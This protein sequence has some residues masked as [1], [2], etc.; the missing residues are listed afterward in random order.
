MI[1]LRD[2]IDKPYEGPKTYENLL[3]IL[4][5]AKADISFFGTRCIYVIPYKGTYPIESLV[6]RIDKLIQENIEFSEMERE[7]GEKLTENISILYFDSFT[8]EKHKNFLTLFFLMAREISCSL[9]G[10]VSFAP[11]YEADKHFY[12]KDL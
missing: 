4:T 1:S 10:F 5:E 6:H 8:A 9:F 11:Y 7:I 2:A 12:K 3:G